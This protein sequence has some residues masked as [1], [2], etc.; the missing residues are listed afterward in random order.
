MPKLRK[1]AQK[2]LMN[3]YTCLDITGM[4]CN[5]YCVNVTSYL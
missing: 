2:L 3:W 4:W 5:D 1:S